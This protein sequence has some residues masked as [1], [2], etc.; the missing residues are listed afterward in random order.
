MRGQGRCV[1]PTDEAGR[2]LDRLGMLEQ[3]ITPAKVRQVLEATGR[4]NR[5]ACR[6]THEV[7]LWVLLAMGLFTDLPIRQ[8]FKQARRL[9]VGEASPHRSSLCLAR[10]RLGVEPVLRLFEQVVHPLATP[11]TPGAYYQG[12]HLV[13]IDGTVLNL[14]DSRQ[15][16]AYFGRP[17]GGE[18]GP[19]AFPQLRKLS[20]VEVGTHVEL[21]FAVGTYRTSEEAM[22]PTLLKYLHP[23]MLLLWDRN[24]FSYTLWKDVI[25]RNVAILARL[26]KGMVLAPLQRLSDGSYLAKIYPSPYD[27]KKDRKGIMVRVI[28]YTLDDPQRVGH[29]EEHTLLCSLLDEHA[30]PA[31]E[32]IPEYHER[33]EHELTYDEQKTHQ[34]PARASK[35]T[36]LRSETP[37]GVVQELYALSLAHFVIRSFMFAAAQQAGLD[38]DRL[39]FA[40]CFQILKCRL[41]E[42]DT[43]TW[44]AFQGWYEA[45]LWEMGQEQIPRRRNRINPRVI[46]QKLRKWPTKRPE[47]YRRPPLTKT[48]EESIVMTT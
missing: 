10:Q 22:V 28:R 38:T 47:H 4:I 8:V 16:E 18:R 7:V 42:C 31:W 40:G 27:R 6:L 35:P 41:P 2:V 46:K 11:G 17:S 37:E 33:W 44:Q 32:L 26:Q 39:S 5:R 15:N 23:G 21:A 30:A 29:G 34:D 45:I 36:H 13:A 48:F 20:L 25:S 19:G 3:V 14:P 1:L 43:T 12:W 9:R 24:F